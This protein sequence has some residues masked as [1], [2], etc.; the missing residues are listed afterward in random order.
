MYLLCS[1]YSIIMCSNNNTAD[2]QRAVYDNSLQVR[3][4]TALL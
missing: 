1:N 3:V 4:Q 2:E